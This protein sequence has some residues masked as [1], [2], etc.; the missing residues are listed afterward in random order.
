MVLVDQAAEQIPPL[1]QRHDL[2]GLDVTPPLRYSQLDP[3][4]RSLGI[5]VTSI[6]CKDAIEMTA[7]EDQGPIEDLVTQCL[8]AALGEGIRPG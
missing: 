4:V 3:A 5:V 2:H 1:D 8:H 7:A 6:A